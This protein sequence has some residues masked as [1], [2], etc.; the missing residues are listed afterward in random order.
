M[1]ARELKETFEQGKT[2]QISD[3]KRMWSRK[4]NAIYLE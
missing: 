4:E 2:G 3:I 1:K